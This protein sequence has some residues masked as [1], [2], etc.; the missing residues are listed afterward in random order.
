MICIDMRYVNEILD[1]SLYT[2]HKVAT[3]CF[4][5][6]LLL[7]SALKNPTLQLISLDIHEVKKNAIPC[8]LV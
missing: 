8:V 6:I 4:T 7:K 2:I 5:F 1:L 3:A